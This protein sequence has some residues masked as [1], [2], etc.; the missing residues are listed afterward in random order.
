MSNLKCQPL[1]TRINKFLR[2]IHYHL[3]RTQA[4]RREIISTKMVQFRQFLIR[5][6]LSHLPSSIILTLQ[7]LTSSK[8]PKTQF[9]QSLI[10]LALNHLLTSRLPKL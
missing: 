9:H 1:T 5:L 8:G 10:G 7:M 3:L 4:H 2:L 6:A